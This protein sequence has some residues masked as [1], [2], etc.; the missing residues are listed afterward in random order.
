MARSFVD[1][2]VYW[3]ALGL[4]AVAVAVV[5]LAAA[6]TRPPAVR[7]ASPPSAVPVA[8]V[9]AAAT[10]PSAVAPRRVPEIT[11]E[12]RRHGFHACNPPDRIGL[13]PYRSYVRT[14]QGRMAIPQRGG[15]TLDHGYDV[16]V[17]FHG[18]DPVRK[19]VVQA[20]RGIVYVAIDKGLG[21]GPY[22]DAFKLPDAWQ[23]LKRSIDAELK[24]HTA[25]PAAHVRHFAL[26]SWSA[27]YGAIVQI[28]KQD[29]DSIDAVIL[30][31]S[32]HATYRYGID[33]RQRGR[34]SSVDTLTIAPVVEYARRA[35]AG[36]KI[37][38][39]THSRVDPV[40]Y[41]SVGLSADALLREIGVQRKPTTGQL[42]SLTQV[43]AVDEKGLHVWAYTGRDELTHCAHISL[44]ER[45]LSQI[46]EVAWQTPELDRSVPPSPP[47]QLG[48][49]RTAP[50]SSSAA[51]LLELVPVEEDEPAMPAE[52]P[53]APAVV[54]DAP[55]VPDPA[56][57]AAETPT[58]QPASSPEL[59]APA[60]SGRSAG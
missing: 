16:L 51:P 60:T 37:L 26:S 8:S 29:A 33:A 57:S 55:V 44:I 38:V 40:D 10:V 58:N 23:T 31:D 21:S 1:A 34:V 30:L 11:A 43:N 14:S 22:S 17:H 35:L 24:R 3:R 42:G 41:P 36:E 47:P 54:G 46:V 5:G 18:A 28:L 2:P 19:T 13:G 15:M 7:L 4:A 9:T 27:G 52:E 50:S 39:L 45:A 6:A 20:S 53:F 12:E 32:L 49:A 56:G 25:D 59:A 48:G